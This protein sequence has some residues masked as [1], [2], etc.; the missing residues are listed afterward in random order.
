VL[1]AMVSEGAQGNT[2][3][4][5]QKV[6]ALPPDKNVTY[7]GF[8]AIR[9]DIMVRVHSIIAFAGNL[10]QCFLCAANHAGKLADQPGVCCFHQPANSAERRIQENRRGNKIV[11]MRFHKI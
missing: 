2:L 4:E 9:S 1:L 11:T 10:L 5:L 6:L 3:Q 7:R 8:E